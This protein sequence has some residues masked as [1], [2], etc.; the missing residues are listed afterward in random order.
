MKCNLYFKTNNHMFNTKH[1]CVFKL[2]EWVIRQKTRNPRGA[3]QICV[4]QMLDNE[5]K[6]LKHS[7]DHLRHRRKL[8]GNSSSSR[9][10]SQGHVRRGFSG[11][12]CGGCFS[13][14]RNVPN[15]VFHLLGWPNMFFWFM[16]VAT[17]TK[18][19]TLT[20]SGTALFITVL[21][22]VDRDVLL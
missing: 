13:V 10:G 17:L 2:Y 4:F 20:N 3:N 21:M 22:R 19:P 16:G 8:C 6:T 7:G 9:P 1:T 18:H 15:I 5:R 14:S 12:R 11:I